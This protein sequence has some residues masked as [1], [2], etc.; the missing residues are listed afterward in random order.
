MN[1]QF[2]LQRAIAG[3]PIETEA[4]TP[5]EF[6]AYRPTATHAHQ[7]VVQIGRYIY[8][9][10]AKGRSPTNRAHIHNLRMK[11]VAKQIN[12]TK[13]P[14]DTLITLGLCSGNDDRY[15]SSFSSGMVHY[16]QGGTTS[17]TADSNSDVFTINPSNVR[18]TPNQPWTIWLGGDCPLPDGLEFE[19]LIQDEPGQVMVGK[20][21]A[22]SYSWWPNHIYAYRLT[23]KVLDGYF[24]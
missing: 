19:Y 20:E 7:V 5:V 15:F 13:L 23:G 11:S 8:T 9:Y 10:S 18:I 3:E 1:N 2:D 17:K 21:S 6:V 14:V 16:Y 22:S 24:L 4:G 12:W